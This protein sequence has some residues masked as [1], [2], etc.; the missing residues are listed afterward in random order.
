MKADRVNPG[1][2]IRAATWE[3][4]ESIASV[5]YQSFA[6]FEPAYTP[7]A[8]AATTPTGDQIR[9]RWNE[10]PV[11]VAV[12]NNAIA[13]TVSAVVRQDSLYVRSMAVLP[14]SNDVTLFPAHFEARSQR[15]LPGLD[16]IPV[17]TLGIQAHV[18]PDGPRV[19]DG[20]NR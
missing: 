15:P 10:G 5:L 8:Y 11:W 17:N 9:A 14:A 6:E 7:E 4:T 1:V 19:A 18:P 3:D 20:R 2:Q 16:L 13:G 12:S